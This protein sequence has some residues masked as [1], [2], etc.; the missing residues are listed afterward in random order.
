M[1]IKMTLVVLQTLQALAVNELLNELDDDTFPG[2]VDSAMISMTAQLGG[3][4][5][6]S[7]LSMDVRLLWLQHE[8]AVLAEGKGEP[9]TRNM[10]EFLFDRACENFSSNLKTEI[11]LAG[12]IARNPEILHFSFAGQEAK[13]TIIDQARSGLVAS[14]LG[15]SDY[16]VVDLHN[17]RSFGASDKCHSARV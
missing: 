2:D 8:K 17:V 9:V 10:I 14:Y 6:I 4:G 5:D 7:R 15:Y 12:F 1:G 13:K 16:G 3:T 11:D